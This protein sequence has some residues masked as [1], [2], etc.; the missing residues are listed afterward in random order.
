MLKTI[1]KVATREFKCIYR[2]KKV[3]V[4]LLLLP[5]FYAVLFGYLY[6]ENVVTGIKTA[7]VNHSPS[8]L[9]RNIIEGFNKSEKFNLKM[10]LKDENEIKT[11]IENGEIDAAI[12]IPKDFTRDIKKGKNSD[13]LIIVNGTNMLISNSTMTNALQIVETYSTG[14]AIKKYQA[15][16]VFKELAYESAKPI[17]F[18]IRPWYNPTFNYTNFLLL[19]LIAT[20]IQQIT[21][22]YVAIS[23]AKEKERGTIKELLSFS[24]RAVPLV[25]GKIL[26][27]FLSAAF[28][29]SM[30]AMVGFK[31]FNIP[32]RGNFFVLLALGTAFILCITALGVMLSIICRNELEATQLSMLVAV[33]SFLFSG[34]TWPLQSMPVPCQVIAKMLPL[35]YFAESFRRIAL[36]GIGFEHITQ[37]AYILGSLGII[38][39]IIAIVSFKIKY[40]KGKTSLGQVSAEI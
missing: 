33:P 12:I 39:T 16:G 32:M 2:D 29:L 18:K 23:I 6:S 37:N 10:Q 15:Q 28:T 14:I 31:V 4:I 20:A 21:L 9:S 30:A 11:Y 8:Q 22:M 35:T 34:Y 26:P 5:I 36:M 13:I 24:D 27:Y 38:F 3:L 19:G 25:L 1:W 40:M 17:S 7:V